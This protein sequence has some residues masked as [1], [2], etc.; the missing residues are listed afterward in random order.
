M[1]FEVLRQYYNL[2]DPKESLEPDD[3]RNVD[4]DSAG[5]RG[6]N[7]APKM[8]REILL[9]D[10]PSC[11]FFTGLPGTGKSTELKRLAGLMKEKG[12]FPVLINAEEVLDL[13]NPIDATEVLATLVFKTEEAVLAAKKKDPAN[14]MVDGYLTRLWD[15]LKNTDFVLGKGNFSLPGG[16]GKLMI[17]MKTRP[18]LRARIRETV[19]ANFV[20]FLAE[21]RQEIDQLNKQIKDE[22]HE[23]LIIILDSLE[24]LRGNTDTWD[25]VMSSAE[26]LF[27]DGAAYLRLPVHVVY[28]VPAT[29]VTRMPGLDFLPMIKVITPDGE[30]WA[31]GIKAARHMIRQR[32]P[33]EVLN[34]LMGPDRAETEARISRLIRWSGGY[35]RQMMQLLRAII[36]EEQH[37]VSEKVFHRQLIHL[38]NEYSEM[39][40]GEAYPWLARVHAE[41][42]LVIEDDDHRR[43]AGRMLA[44][45]VVLRY[46]NDT[47]WFDLHPAVL[48]ISGVQSAID[49]LGDKDA[50]P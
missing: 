43:I 41:K 45:H 21:V 16:P 19:S 2:C 30:S 8:T 5:V 22:G 24:K 42:K 6:S 13:H 1:D 18:A 34:A 33:D 17:E 23:G 9:S 40:P 39:V 44:N 38:T 35:P 49:T 50:S 46:M 48:T 47:L 36:A 37:P 27:S 3:A 20:H 15:W 26:R 4:L 29:L 10:R 25:Q 14:A 7:W 28:T 11:R 32:I 12:L 31:Q